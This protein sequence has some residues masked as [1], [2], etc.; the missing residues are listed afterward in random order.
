MT[1]VVVTCAGSLDLIMANLKSAVAFSRAPLRLI[2][3]ADEENIKLLQDRVI[4]SA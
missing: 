3:Y 2:L 1:F 4:H